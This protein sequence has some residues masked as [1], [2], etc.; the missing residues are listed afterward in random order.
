LRAFVPPILQ[1]GRG[2]TALLDGGECFCKFALCPPSPACGR[3]GGGSLKGGGGY[4][5]IFKYSLTGIHPPPTGTP[6]PKPEYRRDLKPP[7]GD[8]IL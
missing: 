7:K 1:F 5:L 8:K 3:Q 4:W 2:W 6:P